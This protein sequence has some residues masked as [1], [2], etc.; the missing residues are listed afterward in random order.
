M[1]K[2]VQRTIKG[3]LVGSLVLTQLNG[4]V[5]LAE[6]TE[7]D[8]KIDGSKGS[9]LD[10]G[11]KKLD[12]DLISDAINEE[13]LS[14]EEENSDE[15]S[16]DKDVHISVEDSN[17]VDK[18][19]NFDISSFPQ[20]E[21]SL[22]VTFEKLDRTEADAS[23]ITYISPLYEDFYASG[24]I[25][26]LSDNEF[27]EIY[28]TDSP[29]K[30][31][32]KIGSYNNDKTDFSETE[33][34]LT[35]QVYSVSGEDYSYYFEIIH[36][37]A[38]NYVENSAFD[39][40]E[41]DEHDVDIY[42]VQPYFVE[43]EQPHN[44]TIWVSDFEGK[45]QVDY[46]SY[47]EHLGEYMSSNN[48][49]YIEF[50]TVY[51]FSHNFNGHTEYFTVSS[52]SDNDDEINQEE[53]QRVSYYT[54]VQSYGWME[55]VYDG[56]SSGVLHSDKRI[57]SIVINSHVPDVS[58]TYSTHVQSAGWT[59][60]VKDGE[61]SGT[62][63][64]G[65]RIEAIK[66][67]LEGDLSEN[68]VV[69][70]RVYTDY[71]GWLGWAKDGEPA[72]T[73][74]FGRKIE[75]IEI[76]L[77]P[78]YEEAP[79]YYYD[80]F[81]KK[82]EAP[83]LSYSTHVQSFGWLDS[84]G[85][86]EMSG[87]SGKAKRMEAIKID[88][89]NRENLGVSYR[90]HV[91][92]DGWQ[93]WVD[94]NELSGTSNQAKRLEAIEIQ[95][96]GYDAYDYD[97]YY[98]VHAESY[99]WL[100]WAK[101]GESA[102]TE[103]LAKRLE[104]IE[105]RI[106]EK[107]EK[108][109][110]RT[111]RPYVKLQPTVSY[112]THVQSHGWQGWRQNGTLAGTTGQAKRLEAIELRVQ[113]SLY[114]GGIKYRTHV[115][116]YGW[117]DWKEN[118]ALSGTEGEAKRLEAIQLELTDELAREFDLYY[119]VHAESYGWLGWAKNGQYAGTEGL[120]KRLES[121]EVKLVEKNGKAPGDTLNRFVLNE[122]SKGKHSPQAFIGF[123]H[124]GNEDFSNLEYIIVGENI[125]EV[126]LV[127]DNFTYREYSEMNQDGEYY[128][129]S[130]DGQMSSFGMI[131]IDN[132]DDSFS[133]EFS[134]TIKNKSGQTVRYE[135]V[136][137]EKFIE[138]VKSSDNFHWFDF[139]DDYY[140]TKLDE[141]QVMY[142]QVYKESQNTNDEE[143]LTKV[144]DNYLDIGHYVKDSYI[145]N[146]VASYIFEHS[147]G[148]DIHTNIKDKLNEFDNKD[149]M[150]DYANNLVINS[151]ETDFYYISKV[152]DL[153]IDSQVENTKMDLYRIYS[154]GIQG[155]DK[156]PLIVREGVVMRVNEEQAYL[157]EE[158]TTL[159]EEKEKRRKEFE[160]SLKEYTGEEP[161]EV[162]ASSHDMY[163][164][165]LD[166]KNF[167]EVSDYYAA[168]D[169]IFDFIEDNDYYF[170]N[171]RIEESRLFIVFSRDTWDSLFPY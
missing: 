87:T 22:N 83:A 11:K 82:P 69:Y 74:G 63:G 166:M 86:G 132:D 38:D 39:I 154:A 78:M 71:D 171:F 51:K 14:I 128:Y 151:D 7:D 148:D 169:N 20:A 55:E 139:E 17:K 79:H 26:G 147:I 120:A 25:E 45:L 62:T 100:D 52:Y 164:I 168:Q 6:S 106:V 92:R 12:A 159:P 73:E 135:Y 109:P 24:L 9:I 53:E 165:Q 67:D 48:P 65:R 122:R 5:A 18:D 150:I 64:L 90:T 96:T 157:S 170:D 3:F 134:L 84:V 113:N 81:I 75:G 156:G 126:E 40:T 146:S 114:E 112:R 54:H 124:F 118:G 93:D 16:L 130:P 136:I 41:V 10:E 103:G 36:Y 162:R 57:E 158:D 153:Y 76:L 107:G 29:N 56:D 95:L 117:Q 119:R 13:E 144:I 37:H 88:I 31:N 121:I 142:D 104:A 141:V 77:L 2:E 110:G 80:S 133:N 138:T 58:M 34:L 152:Y 33:T 160:D 4:L 30:V 27:L 125:A 94:S 115:Q 116:S 137:D 1:R 44:E 61:E 35:N 91:Q 149:L 46:V 129:L 140:Y 68:Y 49:E 60:W 105:I 89:P 143:D 70:Y 28:G 15:E 21:E 19:S 111:E 99:G 155:E 98:R 131:S 161:I 32:V 23:L 97:I 50:D 127:N 47:A 72:G 108:S 163:Y 42:D 102:G 101:N 8:L 43:T 59:D 123:R 85:N 167:E 145:V 66:I